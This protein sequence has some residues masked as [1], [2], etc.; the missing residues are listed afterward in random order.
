MLPAMTGRAAHQS[1]LH[2]WRPRRRSCA[3]S[4]GCAI[5]WG[6]GLLCQHCRGLGSSPS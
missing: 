5:Q 4:Y 6:P 3:N 1:L 2:C